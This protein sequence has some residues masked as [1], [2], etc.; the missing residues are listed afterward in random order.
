MELVKG[1]N[2]P[3]DATLAWQLKVTALGWELG[4]VLGGE[5]GFVSLGT[6]PGIALSD[7]ALFINISDIDSKINTIVLYALQSF[8]S[9]VAVDCCLVSSQTGITFAVCKSGVIDMALQAIELVHIYKI[10]GQW[11]IKSYFQGYSGG[12]LDLFSSR[13]ISPRSKSPLGQG[14]TAVTTLACSLNWRPSST[15]AFST[16]RAYI[17]SRSLSISTLNLSCLY[18][19][20]NGQ[21]GVI[22]GG[23]DGKNQGS[24]HGVPFA[25]IANDYDTGRCSLVFN[26]KYSHKMYRYVVC[27]EMTEG[28]RCWRD[29]GAKLEFTNGT[30][31]MI[32]GIDSPLHTP[33]YVYALLEV[34]DGSLQVKIIDQYF[35]NYQEIAAVSGFSNG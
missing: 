19:L 7:D 8:S 24:D 10:K 11:K 13:A 34:V 3:I 23:G 28:S 29:V 9:S 25:Q 33:I 26:T 27:A 20:K 4:V 15:Q 6:E 30:T 12:E 32:Q 31:A 35:T 5:E 18:V 21:R 22:H 16:S 14:H 1:Q 2:T 17:D